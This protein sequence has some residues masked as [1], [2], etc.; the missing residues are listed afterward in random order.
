MHLATGLEFVYTGKTD[1][2]TNPY[3][4]NVKGAHLIIGWRTAKD[5]G[6]FARNPRT[7]GVGGNRYYPGYQ[8]ADGSITV[9]EP[10]RPYMGGLERITGPK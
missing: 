2:K 9:P 8:E 3:G 5:Y 7:A 10:L 6:L 1:Q 4:N